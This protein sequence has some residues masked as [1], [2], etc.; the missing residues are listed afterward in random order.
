M[1]DD[2]EHLG[3]LALGYLWNQP[4]QQLNHLLDGRRPEHMPRELV[5][6]LA[7]LTTAEKQALKRA[8]TSIFA[9]EI[10]RLFTALDDQS[11][12]AGTMTIHNG[13]RSFT[14]HLPPWEDQL[15]YFDREG[16]PKAAAA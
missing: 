3:I 14:R 13:G 2:N 11:Q 9:D 16:N 7:R 5:T 4:V 12:R 6:A 15:S 10:T 8:I 1:K